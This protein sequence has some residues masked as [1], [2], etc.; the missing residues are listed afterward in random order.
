METLILSSAL[1]SRDDFLLFKEH[2]DVKQWAREF[3]ILFGL[4][5]A[6]YHRDAN[7]QAV[8]V[9]L[10]KQQIVAAYPVEKHADKF[11]ALVDEAVLIEPPAANIR[12]TVLVAKRHGLAQALAMA[13]A[14]GKEHADVLE[15]YNVVLAQ[16]SLAALDDGIETYTA[17]DIERLLNEDADESKKLPI[18][19]RALN[20]RLE[21]GLKPC[22]S[23][24]LLARP[25]LGKTALILTMACGLA[26]RGYR[27]IIF[28]NEERIERLYMRAISC[29]TGL[30]ARE[31]RENIPYARQL[32]MDNGFSNL[33]FVALSPGSPKQIDAELEKYPDAAAFIVDQLRNLT[34]RTDNKTIQ[35]EEAAKDI[36]NIAKRRRLVSI[37]VTQAGDS[38]ENKS[39]LGMGDADG[40][41]TGIPGACD[42]MLGVGA[43]E[44][45]K[46]QGI[47]V[48]TPIKNKIS[49][50]HEPFPVRI[51]QFVSKY[52]S[53]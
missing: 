34:I 46:E 45:Q 42:V 44:Q 22:D 32:A 6:Y 27:V 26:S 7:V 24:I 19:P 11:K 15:Q 47:R 35:L 39:V 48:L 49:G 40:S 16:E 12:D 5:D 23:M 18:M 31:V 37:A 52:V 4:I 28:N 14:N 8:D 20:D 13:I 50:Q 51:N 38:A 25:E 10:L 3:Q 9:Q 17:D 29:I 41:N 1:R 21:G 43:D 33:V 30:T 53:I 2:L 36:R